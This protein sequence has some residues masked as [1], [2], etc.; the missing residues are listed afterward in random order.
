MTRVMRS[1]YPIKGKQKKS[2]SKTL[3]YPK[4]KNKM[5]KKI[6]TKSVIKIKLNKVMKN[7][8]KK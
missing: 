4:L 6:R 3:N 1:D 2:W 8:I 7:K 5:N